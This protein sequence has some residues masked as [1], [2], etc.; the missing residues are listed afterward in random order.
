MEDTTIY[1]DDG[2]DKSDIML[3]MY[4]KIIACILSGCGVIF[5]T[6]IIFILLSIKGSLKTH[7]KFLLSLSICDLLTGVL[8]V[9]LYFKPYVCFWNI[10]ESV[11]LNFKPD[12]LV[13]VLSSFYL[14]VQ[15]ATLGTMMLLS[16]DL[17]IKVRYPLT[18]CQLL[19][20]G[21]GNAL[22]VCLWLMAFIPVGY[23][24]VIVQI[25]K[26][27]NSFVIN[28][29][30]I[31][32]VFQLLSILFFVVILT[33]SIVSYCT[34]RSFVRR[35]PSSQD[36][37]S[38]KAAVTFLALL[39]TYFVCLLPV[40]WADAF[41]DPYRMVLVKIL[42]QILYV[43]NTIFDPIIYALRIPE[44]QGVFNCVRRRFTSATTV[45]TSTTS[46]S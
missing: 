33:F 19:S 5:N 10:K 13:L 17:L 8:H 37:T 38:R 44:V 12:T 45:N 41:Y 30:N 2:E 23:L 46:Q 18:Y 11:K 42:L 27:S 40:L 9:A 29:L 26:N 39:S 43:L 22:T 6:I 35:Q 20:K 36:D 16:A 1:F 14:I 3:V 34:I 25:E 21:K 32:N 4:L 7:L 31:G 15:F 24:V 28:V